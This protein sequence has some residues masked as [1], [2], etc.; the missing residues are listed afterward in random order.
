MQ[1]VKHS[2]PCISRLGVKYSGSQCR[3]TLTRRWE[4][5][6]SADKL[7]TP[8]DLPIVLDIDTEVRGSLCS[9]DKF[10]IGGTSDNRRMSIRGLPHYTRNHRLPP[11]SQGSAVIGE[12][13]AHFGS[14]Q[15]I[16]R[17]YCFP[18]QKRWLT[19]N[20]QLYIHLRMGKSVATP[21]LPPDTAVFLDQDSWRC[22][23]S[24]CSPNVELRHLAL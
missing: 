10:D 20:G 4:I 9:T 24:T 11:L 13:Y 5:T 2:S 19:A 17:L 7:L 23:Y 12:V 14:F 18:P 6:G 21:P 16:L 22:F 3:T 8:W 15:W 1:A